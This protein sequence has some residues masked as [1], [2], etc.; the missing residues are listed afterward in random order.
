M[1]GVTR[2]PAGA[3]VVCA[4]A[5]HPHPL[6]LRVDGAVESVAAPGSLLGLFPDA[7]FD[8]RVL[9]LAAGDALVLHTDGVSE[10]RRGGEE[11]GA[12][13]VHSALER[14]AGED[15]AGIARM[16]EEEAI[17]FSDGH[18]RDDVAIVVVRA[19]PG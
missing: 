16:L 5:G 12:A 11:L 2:L 14:A 7:V 8:E 13:G 15:A 6:V 9:D 18:L 4:R 10:A 19:A 17:A 3:R 1:V